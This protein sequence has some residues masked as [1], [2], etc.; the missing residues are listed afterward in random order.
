M[1]QIIPNSITVLE[2][3]LLHTKIIT[4]FHTT[5]EKNTV[6][7]LVKTYIYACRGPA[8]TPGHLKATL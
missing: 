2:R 6:M 4:H 8:I 1:I 3:E 5:S 7:S